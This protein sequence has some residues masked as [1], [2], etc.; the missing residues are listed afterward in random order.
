MTRQETET[1]LFPKA[2]FRLSLG[3]QML[4]YAYIRKNAC[5]AFKKL[6][7]GE[8]A[9]R[10]RYTGTNRVRFLNE[11]HSTRGMTAIP[12]DAR[13][14]LVLRNPY[15]RLVSLYLNKFV[16]RRGYKDI[17][18]SYRRLTGGDPT[19]V[20]FLEFL[21]KYV[22]ES[23]FAELDPHVLPQ[24]RHLAAIPYNSPVRFEHLFDDLAKVIG[25]QYADTYFKK[26]TNN[27]SYQSTVSE[28]VAPEFETFDF[29]TG[30]A[31]LVEMHQ[32]T[33]T[34]PAPSCFYCE[35]L[36]QLIERRYQEDKIAFETLKQD[37]NRGFG[38]PSLTSH[39]GNLTN[40]AGR[41]ETI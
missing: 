32:K 1:S 10:K 13:T 34:V 4:I 40:G 7:L 19:N 30:S 39:L 28:G 17:F 22:G 26:K 20:T 3:G 9:H 24:T 29:Q 36:S 25:Q 18:N 16:V 33:G 21:T 35:E 8:S 15:D 12:K 38:V 14:M 5:S 27:T 2:H 37:Y 23:P 31:R 41:K 6:F 11:Y